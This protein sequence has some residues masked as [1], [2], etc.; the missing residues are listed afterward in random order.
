MRYADSTL[1]FDCHLDD[2]INMDVLQRV[3]NGVDCAR[4]DPNV[5]TMSRTTH[6]LLGL[7]FFEML[8]KLFGLVKIYIRGWCGG[9]LSRSI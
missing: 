3:M 4:L 7:L 2:V 1:N 5:M 6:R 8:P 9:E